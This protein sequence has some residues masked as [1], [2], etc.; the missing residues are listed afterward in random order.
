MFH[1]LG[2]FIIFL[3]LLFSFGASGCVDFILL[4]DIGCHV[5]VYISSIGLCV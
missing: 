2:T 1:A 4:Q 5:L 3:L